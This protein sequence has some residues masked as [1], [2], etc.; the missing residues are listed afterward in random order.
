MY[1]IE[2]VIWCADSKNVSGFCPVSHVLTANAKKPKFFE[3]N[4]DF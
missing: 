2:Y 1:F 4:L 3:E